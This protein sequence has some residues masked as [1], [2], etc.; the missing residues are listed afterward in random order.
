MQG[1]KILH[2]DLTI[3]K[4]KEKKGNKKY[5]MKKTGLKKERELVM[6]QVKSFWLI[7]KWKSRG[8]NSI[9]K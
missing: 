2:K 1:K 9:S 6:K 7:K 8:M 5:K 3:L 4:S